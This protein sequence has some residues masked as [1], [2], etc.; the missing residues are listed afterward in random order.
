MIS[1][2]QH[3][4]VLSLVFEFVFRHEA[5]LTFHILPN[6]RKFGYAALHHVQFLIPLLVWS[7]FTTSIRADT[8]IVVATLHILWELGWDK[9]LPAVGTTPPVN[10]LYLIEK[11]LLPQGFEANLMLMEAY[12]KRVYLDMGVHLF[13]VWLYV[14]WPKNV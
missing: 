9:W 7:Y 6:R 4:Y 10:V 8:V 2:L 3:I 14:E 13:L 1:M 12:N 5:A 11:G